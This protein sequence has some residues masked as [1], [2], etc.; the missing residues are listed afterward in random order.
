[1]TKFSALILPFFLFAQLIFANE[2]YGLIYNIGES[3]TELQTSMDITQGTPLPIKDTLKLDFKYSLVS[4]RARFGYIA[5]LIFNKSTTINILIN[6]T[7]P[8]NPRVSVIKDGISFI[9][10]PILNDNMKAYNWNDVSLRVIPKEGVVLVDINGETSQYGL[11]MPEDSSVE[12][13]FGA[14]D[15]DGFIV[16]DVP[17]VIVRDVELRSGNIHKLWRLDEYVGNEVTD[18]ISNDKIYIKNPRWERDLHSSWLLEYEVINSSKLFPI[19][20][21]NKTIHVI[22]DDSVWDYDIEWVRGTYRKFTAPISLSYASNQFVFDPYMDRIRYFDSFKGNSFHSSLNNKTMTWEPQID[23]NTDAEYQQ[24]NIFISPTDS[25]MVQLFGYGHFIYKSSMFSTSTNGVTT[26][27]DLTEKIAPRYLASTAVV[28]DWCYV[29]G[30]VGNKSGRQELG[31]K[32]LNDLHRINLR[33]GDVEKIWET[34]ES[35]GE[36]VACRNMLVMPDNPDYAISLL[37][38]STSS[39]SHLRLKAIN[40]KEPEIVEV[41]HNPIPYNFQDTKSNVQLVYVETLSKLFALI[42]DNIESG[43]YRLR[44]YSIAYPVI[45]IP[46]TEE[47]SASKNPIIATIFAILILGGGVV[48]Y[49][50]KKRPIETP[51]SPQTTTSQS[52]D[53]PQREITILPRTKSTGI[54]LLDGFTIIDRDN[55]DITNEFAPLMKQLLSLIILYTHKNGKGVSNTILKDV[56]WFDKSDA[57]ARNNRS[58]TISKIRQVLQRVGDYQLLFNN[59]YWHIEYAKGDYCD[60]AYAC[61]TIE[62]IDDADENKRV[63]LLSEVALMGELLPNQMFDFFDSFKAQYSSN[64][65]DSMNSQL[66]KCADLNDK[67]NI[68]DLILRFDKIDESATREKCLALIEMG[69]HGV[70]KT[71]FDNFSREYATLFGSEYD[72]SFEEFIKG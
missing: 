16:K 63:A 34:N 9:N 71:T 11:S 22:G 66:V 40:L 15:Y 56:L 49:L 27:L 48:F 20:N 43:E 70:A 60:Y 50:R 54:Y 59:S 42:V 72:S 3:N 58:V 35:L 8:T 23:I 36:E 28:D 13:I 44:I 1:M 12:V 32:N 26:N 2:N 7:K 69:K 67:V 10:T 64:V 39:T 37:Y 24:G 19:Y 51:T 29:Y 5:R 21:G 65:I 47:S 4:H 68:A 31:S 45:N 62:N 61:Q 52:G 30:G 6:N 57:S 14:N 53:K 46:P 38:N 25:A 17:T 55:V 41:L 33:T 18:E